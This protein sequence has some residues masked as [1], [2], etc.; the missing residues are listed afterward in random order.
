MR[1]ILASSL[2]YAG[3]TLTGAGVLWLIM[4]VPRHSRWLPALTFTCAGVV[5]MLVAWSLPADHSQAG[6]RRTQLDEFMPVYEFNEVH[7]I[8][9]N[10]S[11][12][13]VYRAILSVTAGEIT[14]FKTLTWIRRLGRRTRE[15][16]MN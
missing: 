2:F 7:T 8:Q 11:R 4:A 14:L 1:E 12:E 6:E 10:A 3:L 9:I 5:L 13:Q 15:S 16:I